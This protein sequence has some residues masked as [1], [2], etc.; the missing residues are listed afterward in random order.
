MLICPHCRVRAHITSRGPFRYLIEAPESARSPIY[1]PFWRLKGT[2]FKAAA[3]KIDPV[4]LDSSIFARASVFPMRS[5]GNR[6][7]PPVKYAAAGAPGRFVPPGLDFADAVLRTDNLAGGLRE[8][9][10]GPDAFEKAY[11]NEAAGIVFVPLSVDGGNL[12]DVARNAPAGQAPS[13]AVW[14]VLEGAAIE[15]LRWSPRFLSSMC[16]NCG[17]DLK[18]DKA[19]DVFLC[20]NC[21]L[22]WQPRGEEFRPVVVNTIPAK[23]SD[24]VYLPFWRIGSDISGIKLS[25][26]A[27]LIRVANLPKA[28]KK[29]WETEDFAFWTPAFRVHPHLF[30]RVAK[31][32]TITPFLGT[33]EPRAP[34]GSVHP[35]NL[36]LVEAVQTLKV[37]LATFGTPKRTI[38]QKLPEISVAPRKAKLVFVPCTPRGGELVQEELGIAVSKQALIYGKDV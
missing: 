37:V 8:G 31:Q 12:V 14:D 29:E 36:P 16:P 33:L 21:N 19:A 5:L 7:L 4:A 27:D 15:G 23:G 30:L 20:K 38:F 25:T 3:F 1:L 17:W 28:I 34:E 18:G 11:V 6:Q 9:A 10:S 26:Y 35:V 13:P 2:L 22:G 24:F 32:V